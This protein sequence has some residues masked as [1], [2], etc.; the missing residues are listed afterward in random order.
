[1]S[2]P[3][4]IDLSGSKVIAGV[5]ATL[6]GAVAA[7]YLGVAGTLVGAAV[8]SLSST[9]GTEVYRHYLIRS[10][11]RLKAAGVLRQR[12]AA[13]RAAGRHAA[14][15]A[16]SPEKPQAVPSWPAPG[17]APGGTQ[18]VT[19]PVT[20]ATARRPAPEAGGA[21]Q[22]GGSGWPTG[23]PRPAFSSS[24]WPGSPY[25]SCPSASPSRRPCGAA[26]RPGPAWG[27]W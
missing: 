6:T 18:P 11:E 22:A 7:S 4:G 19:S 20:R 14:G 9:M 21:G 26:M 17:R 15:G 16:A 10:Q 5:L 8:G 2:R 1:M 23:R 13:G 27:T 12:W 25:S 3:R 24:S